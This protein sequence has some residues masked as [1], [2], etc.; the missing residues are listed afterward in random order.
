MVGIIAYLLALWW[1]RRRLQA[2]PVATTPPLPATVPASPV[3][4]LPSA[5][6]APTSSI[7][8]PTPPAPAPPPIVVVPT[9]PAPEPTP[10]VPTPPPVV[11]VPT[12]PAPTPTVPYIVYR[13][14]GLSYL[15]NAP[16]W[17]SYR[18]SATPPET[19]G[20]TWISEARVSEYYVYHTPWNGG[21]LLW[22]S[23]MF[24]SDAQAITNIASGVYGP[25]TFIMNPA[26]TIIYGSL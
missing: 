23:R 14:G 1:A 3:V 8:E 11:V 24:S 5:P 25:V 17:G 16:A 15:N 26:G 20:S 13:P 10:P 21:S 9:V 7:P 2:L 18:I 19:G 4:V 22:A 6:A 12:V